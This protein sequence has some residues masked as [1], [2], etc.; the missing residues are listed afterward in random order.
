MTTGIAA[1]ASPQPGH[2]DLSTGYH[3]DLWLDLDALFLRP[4][5]LRPHIRWLA[6][7]LGGLHVDAVCGPAEGGAFLALAIADMLDTAFLPAYRDPEKQPAGYYLPPVTRGIRGWRVAVTDDAINAGT[8][9][10]ACAAEL[11]SQEAVPVAVGA[12]LALGPA[13]PA[14]AVEL[15]VPF[16]PVD[17]MTSQAWPADDCLLCASGILLTRPSS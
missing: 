4:A 7:Q 9:V 14:V 16:Y 6:G 3:G 12:L 5:P 8:A 10:R 13:A 2:F 17:T 11:S 15:S 1:L